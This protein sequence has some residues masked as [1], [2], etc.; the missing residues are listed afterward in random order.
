MKQKSTNQEWHSRSKNWIKGMLVICGLLPPLA[1][2]GNSMMAVTDA[3]YP[4]RN[5]AKEEL[6]KLL[7]YDKILSGNRNTSCATCHHPLAATGDGLSL[8]VGEGGRGLGVMRDTGSGS[9]AVHER[10][11][12]NAPHLFNLGANEF[13]TMFHD[14]RVQK[15]DEASTGFDTPAGENFL[16]GID[17]AL[18]AQA[19][20]PPTSNTEMAG[21]LGENAVA[22]A[23]AAGDVKEVW[24][25]LTERVMA[26][27]EYQE[28]F[29]RAYPEVN[30]PQEVTYTH[31]ANAIG[32]FEAAA[33]RADNSPF[34]RHLRGEN[35]AMSG[36]AKLGLRLFKGK[37]QC[38]T[39]HSGKFQTDHQFHVLGMPQIG[40]G[41]G[42][43]LNGHDDFGREQVTGDW[44][45]RYKFRTPTLRNVAITGPWG[46]DGAYNTLDAVIKHHLDPMNGLYAYDVT[47]AVLPSREDLDAIDFEIYEDSNS[48]SSLA[49]AI[50]I[51]PV[52][53]SD[54]EIQL[55][56]DFLHALTDPASLDMRATAPARVPSGLPLA[57]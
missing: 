49:S 50:E 27:S 31:I 23:A 41:K 57:D 1:V 10:V 52:M 8:S 19:A 28:L 5:E 38:T 21:Q 37:A 51:E 6:G 3:D 33:Y 26:I 13:V 32:A 18:A 4:A 25:L 24:R 48:R 39:C 14:G 44:N 43:G 2:A 22:N 17:S 40:P 45:D 16:L 15:N 11:P 12:R 7:F 35:L 34:D 56:T 47:Q 29:A 30:V 42:D 46:H 9:D 54:E 20:F 53:L 36:R 55:L